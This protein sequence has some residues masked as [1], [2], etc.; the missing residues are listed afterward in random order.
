M[1]SQIRIRAL[2][3]GAVSL[4]TSALAAGPVAQAV[5]VPAPA[6]APAVAVLQ[7]VGDGDHSG[8]GDYPVH[9]GKLHLKFYD[10]QL[11]GGSKLGVSGSGYTPGATVRLS[12]HSHEH[13]LG[14]AFAGPTGTFTKTV[15]LP[16]GVDRGWH[17]IKAVGSDARGGTLLETAKIKVTCRTGHSLAETGVT[18]AERSTLAA[19]A[20]GAPSSTGALAAGTQ[21]D[22]WSTAAAA[23]ALGATALAGAA[24]LAVR[25]HRRTRG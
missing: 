4:L 8:H 1:T 5:A 9:K 10:H 17:T 15:T 12:L 24:L 16:V 7:P 20:P 23:T 3:F 11:C 2:S 22:P 19:G 6:A 13:S 25:A 14:E 21:D 18:A